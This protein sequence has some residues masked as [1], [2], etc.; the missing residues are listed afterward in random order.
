MDG[1]VLAASRTSQSSKHI[2]RQRPS[3]ATNFKRFKFSVILNELLILIV[4]FYL[5]NN[6]TNWS[7]YR[8]VEATAPTAD[9][10]VQLNDNEDAKSDEPS[11]DLLAESGSVE[12]DELISANATAP[13][14]HE[15]QA[16]EDFDIR[17]AIETNNSMATTL[18]PSDQDCPEPQ[19]ELPDNAIRIGFATLYALIL[20]FG[21]F[22]NAITL[23]VMLKKKGPISIMDIFIANL[24]LS[25]ILLC[26]F[27]VPVTPINSLVYGYWTFGRLFCKLFALTMSSSVYISTLTMI[28]IAYHRYELIVRPHKSHMSKKHA[29]LLCASTWLLAF[30]VTLPFL[31]NVDIAQSCLLEHCEEQWQGEMSRFRY[32]II[33][34]MLQF[35]LPLTT[36]SYMYGSIFNRLRRQEQLRR[37]RWHLIEAAT[38]MTSQLVSG[39][40]DC[41]ASSGYLSHHHYLAS[42]HQN[43]NNHRYRNKLGR[44]VFGCDRRHALSLAASGPSAAGPASRASRRLIKVTTLDLQPKGIEPEENGSIDSNY[45]NYSKTAQLDGVING[46]L[47]NTTRFHYLAEIRSDHDERDELDAESTGRGSGGT[48]PASALGAVQLAPRGGSSP[49]PDAELHLSSDSVGA[50]CDATSANITKVSASVL[51]QQ[52]DEEHQQQMVAWAANRRQLATSRQTSSGSVGQLAGI[53]T[54]AGP[55]SSCGLD[56]TSGPTTVTT[57]VAIG[58]QFCVLKRAT[59]DLAPPS[60]R[61]ASV[62][63]EPAEVS[64]SSVAISEQL[65]KL[66]A[67]KAAAF[68]SAKVEQL[69]HRNWRIRQTNLKLLAVVGLFAC[70]WLP[71]N[72]F[73]VVSDYFSLGGD[74]AQMRLIFIIAH[75]FA[76]ISVC[77]NPILYAWMSENYRQELANILPGKLT[78]RLL[79]N[80]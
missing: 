73:N 1:Q 14:W 70:S 32:S 61:R 48:R 46:S 64:A 6:N 28:C 54:I 68:M 43:N 55:G 65:N 24:A 37:K 8:L 18:A 49:S 57:P 2:S 40:A 63:L 12:N 52:I 53:D 39:R 45:T 29:Y 72:M 21:L 19:I 41:T 44:Q 25:D 36:S 60:Q 16:I 75:T 42:H 9:A 30:L 62:G 31:L 77:Y 80:S 33:T 7:S 10:S 67:K 38:P 11:N 58:A 56:G 3:S 15:E 23:Y 76:S 34:L 74:T 27:G 66:Q 4:L 26:A 78:R 69:Q 71:L 13:L 79:S 5:M 22:G 35:F 59:S 47:R 51:Q 20:P 17:S 50:N